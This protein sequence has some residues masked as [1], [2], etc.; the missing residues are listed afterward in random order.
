MFLQETTMLYFS[1]G[2]ALNANIKLGGLLSD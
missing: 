1:K 2:R